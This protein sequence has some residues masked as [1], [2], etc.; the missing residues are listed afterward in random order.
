LNWILQQ[1]VATEY[2]TS[3]FFLFLNIG[4]SVG[5][6]GQI[7][8]TTNGGL[9]FLAGYETS[10]PDDFLLYQNYPNPF[11]P[12]TVIKYFLK[13]NV[14]VKLIIHDITGRE[15]VTIV[16]E[17]Q[18]QG[19]HETEFNSSGLPSGIYFYT[20]FNDNF[21]IDTKKGILIK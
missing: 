9:T 8:M 5:F 3:I 20:L 12:K 6:T 19:I 14:H 18:N 21:K 11:N 7:L 16:N 10:S 13:K 1:R 2:L 4:Y 17:R 15:V